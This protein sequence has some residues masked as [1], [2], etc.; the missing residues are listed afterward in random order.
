[1]PDAQRGIMSTTKPQTRSGQ[2]VGSRPEFAWLFASLFFFLLAYPLVNDRGSVV[3]D[4]LFSGMLVAGA[5]AV[6]HERKV[7]VAALVLAIPTLVFW[8]SVR[9]VDSPPLVFAGLAMSAIFFVFILTLLL[10]HV[11]RSRRANAGT[12]YAAMSAYLLMGVAWSFFYAMVEVTTPGAFDFGALA[13]HSESY[14]R[15]ADLRLFSYYSL[16]TLS[17][18]GYGD[19]TP[20]SPLARSLS[21]LEAVTGQLFI[22]VLLARL[23]GLHVAQHKA[24]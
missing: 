15:H 2:S 13:E 10:R 5:Y 7:L 4:L 19:I 22:A 14:T 1:M 12:I 3:L 21:S 11:I 6:S 17:T 8:W 18:L 20:I 9:I 16:V 23:V 24:N